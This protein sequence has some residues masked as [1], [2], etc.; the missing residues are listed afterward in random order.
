MSVCGGAAGRRPRHNAGMDDTGAYTLDNGNGMRVRILAYGAIVQSIEVP[1]RDGRTAN[2][3]L[4]FPGPEGYAAHPDPYFG[5]V[6]G[7]YAN[8]IAGGRFTLDGTRYA[9]PVNNGPNS[10]HGGE[11]GF[12]KRTWTASPSA[13]AVE[14]TL[15]SPDGDQG[16]PGT[17]T[18]SVTYSLSPDNALT[19]QYRATTDGPTVVNLTNHGYVNLAGE[20]SGTI[21]DHLLQINAAHYTPVD[22]TLIPTGEIAPV[23][24]TPFDFRQP[25][26]IGARVRAADPQLLRAQG[27]DHNWVLDG[28]GLRVAA[29]VSEPVRGRTLTVST[30]EPGLQF[31]SGNFLDGTFTGTGG[32][33]YR[34]GDGLALETQHFPDSPNRPDFP[35]TV[36]RPGE[37]YRSTTVYAF[38]VS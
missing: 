5:A 18:A 19:A 32:R 31:Y 9:V 15:V 29:V 26:P 24:G 20:G 17:L 1:D 3:A 7:R 28:S 8:R 12:D 4:G 37:E 34:Q 21:E 36:L 27:Y 6:V 30:T 25:T 16:Y 23:A 22:E 13:T 2:V 11:T 35:S 33:A 10:L 14:L 38:G